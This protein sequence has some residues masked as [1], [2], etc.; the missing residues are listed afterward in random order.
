METNDSPL[1]RGMALE[2][3]LVLDKVPGMD[4]HTLAKGSGLS[5][6]RLVAALGLILA[7]WQAK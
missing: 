6:A 4:F 2:S 1:A 7:F 5:S 3:R